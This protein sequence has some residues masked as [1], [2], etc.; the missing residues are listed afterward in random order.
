MAFNKSVAEEIRKK[1]K[2][3]KLRNMNIYTLHGLAY[4]YLFVRGNFKDKNFPQL[5]TTKNS[6]IV[7]SVI[8]NLLSKIYEIWGYS[9]NYSF[10][11]FL[12]KTFNMMMSSPYAPNPDFTLVQFK[13]ELIYH[14]DIRIW[15]RISKG[16][17]L[18]EYKEETEQSF[19]EKLIKTINLLWEETKKAIEEDRRSGIKDLNGKLKYTHEGYIKYFQYLLWKK[20]IK[21][22]KYDYILI[23]EA[24][25]VNGVNIGIINTLANL[26]IK[27]IIVGDPHQNI[28]A[29][30][31]AINSFN[32]YKNWEEYPL[33]ISFRFENP[34]IVNYANVIIQKIKGETIPLKTQGV[35]TPAKDV[36]FVSRTNAGLVKFLGFLMDIEN[37]K[38]PLKDIEKTFKGEEGIKKLLQKIVKSQLKKKGELQIKLLRKLEDI[39]SPI[40]IAEKFISAIHFQNIDECMELA[41]KYLPRYIYEYLKAIPQNK[42]EIFKSSKNLVLFLAEFGEMDLTNAIILVEQIGLKKIREIREWVEEKERRGTLKDNGKGKFPIALTTIHT[43]KGLEWDYIV[44]SEDIKTPSELIARWIIG[45]YEDNKLI[46]PAYRKKVIE[47]TLNGI[48]EMREEFNGITEEINLIYVAITRAKKGI[49]WGNPDLQNELDLID[50]D[51]KILKRIIEEKIEEYFTPSISE[52]I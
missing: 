35:E 36:G 23:D 2:K 42:E 4:F 9:V 15:Y 14:E 24:Q 1:Q 11:T 40:I 17:F 26:G 33:S 19:D 41:K 18:K 46:I 34:E 52:L 12:V 28:Y 31:G 38:D 49:V 27:P 51:G 45:E 32:Y 6:E 25:D 10:I 13:K 29:W 43:A 8:E 20:A 37:S 21:I 50:E 48:R 47:E 22:K 16:E 7:Q 30:R 44:L 39:F 3:Q 5:L